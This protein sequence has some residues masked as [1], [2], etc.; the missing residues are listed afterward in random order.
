MEEKKGAKN[1][2]KKSADPGQSAYLGAG[3]TVFFEN[4]ISASNLSNATDIRTDGENDPNARTLENDIALKSVTFGSKG[5]AAV[6]EWRDKLFSEMPEITDELPRLLTEYMRKSEGKNESSYLR[7]A[8]ALKHVFINKTPLVKADDL[9]PGHTTNTVQ[10]PVCYIDTV[11]SVIWPELKTVSARAINPFKIEPEVARRLSREI[12]PYWMRRSIQEV[13]RYSDY[14]TDDFPNRDEVEGPSEEP[15]LKKKAGETPRCQQLYERVAFYIAF[16][17]SC[18]S[19]TVPD[20]NRL[21]KFG[22]RS[23]TNRMDDDINIFSLDDRQREFLDGVKEVFEGAITYAGR[24]ADEAEKV[25]NHELARICRKVPE[26]PAETL[27]EAVVSVWIMYHLLLQENTHYGFSIGRMDQVFQPYYMA[28]WTRLILERASEEDKNAYRTKAV[29]L[30]CHFFLKVSDNIPLSS[31]T[32]ESL[33]AGSGANQALTVGGTFYNPE[34]GGVENAV[35]DMTYIILRATELL[36]VRDPNVH[37]RYHVDIHHRDKN[38]NLLEPS[39]VSPYLKRLCEVNIK[40]RATPA[41]HGD[42]SV[43][44]SLA[45]YYQSHHG[46]DTEEAKAD[47]YD[48]CSIG[49]I[50]ENSAARHYGYTGALNIALSTVLEMAMFGGKHR[51]DG[52]DANAPNWAYGQKDYTTPPIWKMQ[53]MDEF[54][55]AFKFQ[56]DEYAKLTV[57]CHNYMGRFTEKYRPVPLLSGLFIGPTNTPDTPEETNRAKFRDLSSGGAKYNSVGVSVIGIAD[58]I[59]SFCAI[60]NLIF[61]GDHDIAPQ[62]LILAMEADYEEANL[63]QLANSD[64]RLMREFYDRHPLGAKRLEHIKDLIRFG[65]RYGKGTE[66]SNELAVHYTRVIPKIIQDTYYKYR[67]YRG[68]RFLVGYWSMTIHAGYGLLHKAT[69]NLRKNGEAFA[70]GATPCPGLINADGSLPNILDQLY[71]VSSIDNTHVQNGCTYNLTLT[72][73]SDDQYF[74]NDNIRFSQ[75][76]KAFMENKGI[77]VQMSIASI[78]TFKKAHAAAKQAI[79]EGISWQERNRILAPYRD[80]MIRVAGYSAYFVSLSHEMR[81]EIIA[82]ANFALEDGN[83]QHQYSIEL[84]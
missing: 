53:N 80:L 22:L 3:R 27:H 54:I 9:L 14:D 19:H 57:Q 76:V 44:E 81:E 2:R 34:T 43:T 49:C 67:T 35:N 24:L 68:G 8:R 28:D 10:G 65:P 32:A 64:S 17:A 11:G 16:I 56:M 74:E 70:G 23:L 71:S 55:N 1:Q 41:I 84:T 30:M 62:E 12:F 46:V 40:T 36:A 25:G 38:G 60:D 7:R 66:G 48:Y 6:Q 82:R 51:S 21:V 20:F 31:E 29:E 13:S 18:V 77:L 75:Y 26:K 37:A 5:F 33:F 58:V 69:P 73:R 83:D 61:K 78:D 39:E 72:A 63:T 50:E 52:I 79:K 59:D 4:N 42:V 15:P 45:R 47:A